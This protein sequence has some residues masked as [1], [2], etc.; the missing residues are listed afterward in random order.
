MK[1]R[2]EASTKSAH[3]RNVHL[4]LRVL[5]LDETGKYRSYEPERATI[6]VKELGISGW[7]KGPQNYT[8][9]PSFILLATCIP[10]L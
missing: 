10:K 7:L 8:T 2:S 9:K 4:K 1:G 5:Y 3:Q 6:K